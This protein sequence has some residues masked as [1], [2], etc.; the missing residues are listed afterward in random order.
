MINI[1]IIATGKIKEKATYEL[2]N[3]YSKRIS[4]YA[5]INITEIQD[6]N[7]SFVKSSLDEEKIKDAE[8]SKILE[9]LN[10]LNRSY[11]I[12]LEPNGKMI[13]SVNFAKK[14]DMLSINYSSLVYI[15]GG[16]LGLSKDVL[17]KSNEI[18][19]FSPLTFPHQLFRVM[20]LEQIYRSFKI[21]NNETYH[22]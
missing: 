18:I 17:S 2:I 10:K 15:I 6:E 3:E 11:V 8:G 21:N 22:K 5:K 9:R 20:L 16:S 12:S 13:D 4:K 1:E 14:I 7:L 19:S